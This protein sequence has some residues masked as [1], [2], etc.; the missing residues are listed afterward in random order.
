M[1]YNVNDLRKYYDLEKQVKKIYKKHMD[2]LFCFNDTK[3]L[4]KLKDIEKEMLNNYNNDDQYYFAEIVRIADYYN[5][6]NILNLLN[7]WEDI[8]FSPYSHSCYNSKNIDWDYKPENSLRLSDHWNF[9]SN[10][11]IHCKLYN[12]EEYTKKLL[13]CQYINGYY[14]IIEEF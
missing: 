12:N 14:H 6:D 9:E 3:E 11:E 13:L 8:S 4:Q 2:G 1:K 10:G 7:S 5:N